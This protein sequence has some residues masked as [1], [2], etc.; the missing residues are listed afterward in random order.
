MARR[1]DD[2]GPNRERLF[3]R[4]RR[5]DFPLVLIGPAWFVTPASGAVG[6][7]LVGV[8]T[9]AHDDGVLAEVVHGKGDMLQ[10]GTKE[11]GLGEVER[12]PIHVVTRK[13]ISMMFELSS[14]SRLRLVGLVQ[15]PS[16]TRLLFCHAL[17]LTSDL[18]EYNGLLAESQSS[19]QHKENTF[20]FLAAQ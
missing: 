6:N 20:R 5:F 9:P 16:L 10:P 13:S 1:H 17:N 11:H 4:L 14:Q 7:K 18:H 8:E 15:A 12:A 2:D 3:C 19:E